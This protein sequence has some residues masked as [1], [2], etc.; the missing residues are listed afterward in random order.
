M[1]IF[2]QVVLIN[3]KIFNMFIQNEIKQLIQWF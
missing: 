2:M 1:L 3:I